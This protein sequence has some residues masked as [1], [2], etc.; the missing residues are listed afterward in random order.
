[1]FAIALDP[2]QSYKTY[3]LQDQSTRSSLNVVPER[4]GMVT[5]WQV[6]GEELLYLDAE[7]FANP[8]LTVRGGI[9]ILFPICGNLAGDTY[10][11]QGQAYRLPQHGF[12]RNLPWTVTQQ[13]TIQGASITLVLVSNAQTRAVYPFD[14]K[15]EFTYTLK[16]NQLEIF[17]RFT[18]RCG[19]SGCL[20]AQ[21]MPFSAGLHPYFR[22]P[23]KTTLQFDIPAMRYQDQAT[24]KLYDFTGEFDP[25]L[26]EI[27]VI[28]NYPLTGLAAIATDTSRNLRISLSYSSS[29]LNL[30]FWTVREQKYYCLEPWTAPRNALNTGKL[31]THLKPGASC[32]MLV[33]LRAD[34]LE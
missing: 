18:N 20:P 34:F 27:D 17:Q 30:V 4:G 10:E 29:Y 6:Q 13:S 3:V 21:T 24:Q 28:F 25:N 32:E 11:F 33:H 8:N 5:Q 7:R 16:N 1:M 23:D 15:L 26:E 9:P 14:F 22:A 2:D 12:A 19:A 31:L